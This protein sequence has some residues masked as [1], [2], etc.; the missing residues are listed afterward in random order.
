MPAQTPRLSEACIHLQRLRDSGPDEELWGEDLAP[1]TLRDLVDVLRAPDDPRYLLSLWLAKEYERRSWD[2]ELASSGWLDMMAAR[3]LR[4]VLAVDIR[5]RDLEELVLILRWLCHCRVADVLNS[6]VLEEVQPLFRQKLLEG[7]RSFM[8]VDYAELRAVLRRW[9]ETDHGEL[10]RQKRAAAAAASVDPNF[11]YGSGDGELVPAAFAPP[12]PPPPPPRAPTPPPAA[13]LPP[14]APP[15]LDGSGSRMYV[16]LGRRDLRPPSQRT[17]F[18]H[19]V[20]GTD[21][22]PL[23]VTRIPVQPSIL[24]PPKERLLLF[25]LE[26]EP[27]AAAEETQAGEAEMSILATT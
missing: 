22:K 7:M 1:S 4:A 27:D 2:A 26:E 8:S 5:Q 24:P 14:A 21:I 12:A 20:T 9:K 6:R 15:P 18:R 19:R 10:Q 16:N 13:A 25:G 11:H 23:K 3:G 17:T